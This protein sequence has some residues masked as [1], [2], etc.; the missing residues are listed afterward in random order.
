M[1]DR[2]SRWAATIAL[3]VLLAAC[4]SAGRAPARVMRAPQSPSEARQQIALLEGDIARDRRRLG[5]REPGT[6]TAAAQ[7][8]SRK[9][10]PSVPERVTVRPTAPSPAPPPARAENRISAASG[11]AADSSGSDSPRVDRCRHTRAICRAARHICK[12]A[13]YI[14]DDDSRDRCKRARGDCKQAKRVTQC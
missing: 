8:A 4:A 12:L 5:L 14:G 13:D 9:L 1:T 2:A 6:S 11:G 10:K 7:D 3:A